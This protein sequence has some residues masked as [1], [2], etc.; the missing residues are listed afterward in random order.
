MK[1]LGK[2]SFGKAILV[3]C[4]SDGSLAVIKQIDLTEMNKEEENEALFEAKIME[5]LWHQNIIG[6][7]E[8]YKTKSK[9]LCIVMEYADGGDLQSKIKEKKE[10]KSKFKEDEILNI[11]TQIWL[12]IK[13]LHDRKILHRD[14]KSQN[15]F[16]TK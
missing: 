7:K 4:E 8:V 2:G 11:F 15:I 5:P 14:L 13:H 6:F 12:A 10:S 9:K 16:L 3:E 1:I